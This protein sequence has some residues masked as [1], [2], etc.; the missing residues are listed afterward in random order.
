MKKRSF[1]FLLGVILFACAPVLHK[2]IMR[3]GQRSVPME[4]FRANPDLYRGKLFILGGVIVETRFVQEGSQI[5][6]LST[7]VDSRGNLQDGTETSGR[8]LAIYPKDRG[9]LDPVIYE[10]GRLVT[11][12]GTFSD[13]R[14]GKIDDIEYVYPLFEIRQIHLWE[15]APDYYGYPYHPYYPYGYYGPY[16]GHPYRGY[17]YWGPWGPP[18]PGWW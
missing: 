10:K 5:E 2:D 3:E 8:F 7:P 18:P 4:A 12:A 9:T 15:E 1:L 6:V 13:L 14:K 17:P 16:W 11:L